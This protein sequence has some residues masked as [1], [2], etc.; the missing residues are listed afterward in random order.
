MVPDRCPA[1]AGRLPQPEGGGAIPRRDAQ[2]ATVLSRCGTTKAK[3]RRLE[4]YQAAATAACHVLMAAARNT[5]CIWAEVKE[6]HQVANPARQRSKGLGLG[7]SIVKSLGELLGHP[8]SVRSLHG[9]GSV[10]SIEVP[11][12]SSGAS[13]APDERSGPT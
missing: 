5:R 6:Y 3:C 13:S 11:L 2:G 12:T 10:F 8:I 4:N 1:E 9:K 7:L